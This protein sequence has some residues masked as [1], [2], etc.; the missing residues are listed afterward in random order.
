VIRAIT[1]VFEK[2]KAREQTARRI[3]S[4]SYC[5]SAVEELW[6]SEQRGLVGAHGAEIAAP[7]LTPVMERLTALTSKLE[8]ARSIP[9]PGLAAEDF[10]TAL[11][12]TIEKLRA[13]DPDGGFEKVEEELASMETALVKK[14]DKTA[15]E[16]LAR[17]I[18][19][20]VESLMEGTASLRSSAAAKLRKALRHKELRRALRLPALTLF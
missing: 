8:G 14:L 11:A 19:D 18:D 2:R 12:G 16:E 3:N 6:A 1:G 20:R 7:P 4:I 17:E 15:S 13:I 5:A 9:P 10:D